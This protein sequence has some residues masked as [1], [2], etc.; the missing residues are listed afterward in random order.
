MESLILGLGTRSRPT[1]FR[2]SPPLLPLLDSPLLNTHGAQSTYT[3]LPTNMAISTLCPVTCYQIL[4]LTAQT[5]LEARPLQSRYW[6]CWA[7]GHEFGHVHPQALAR[8]QT[9]RATLSA[10]RISQPKS[11]S[12]A[13]GEH[14]PS[15]TQI[16]DGAV[17]AGMSSVLPWMRF[18]GRRLQCLEYL[19]G[20]CFGSVRLFVVVTRPVHHN[21]MLPQMSHRYPPDILTGFRLS[22][23]PMH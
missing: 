4:D 11:N 6:N 9:S 22:P 5:C 7:A 19:A 17:S 21:P 8:R 18:V 16:L 13:L 15:L 20:L 12:R 10:P 3:I 23:L 2:G 1:V 14:I